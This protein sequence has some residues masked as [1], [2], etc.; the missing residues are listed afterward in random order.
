MGHA[1]KS[2]PRAFSTGLLVTAAIQSS[3]ATGLMIT[4]FA[5][6]GLIPLVPG[7][8]VMLGANIGTTL[9]VQVLSFNPTLLAPGFVLAGVWMFRHYAP[10]RAR[11]LGRAF[12]GLGLL[13][14]SLQGL[15]AIF[16][17]LKSAPELNNA[18]QTLSTLPAVALAASTLLTWASHSS[19]AVVVLIMSLAHHHLV[20]PELAYV[21]VLGANLGTAI[22]PVLEGGTR[23]NPASRRLP[24][25]NLG[26]RIVG[27]LSGMV[28][29]PW[30]GTVMSALG[31]DPARAIANFHVLFNLVIAACFLPILKPYA[32]MLQRV[33]P[34]VAGEDEL[35]R[36]QYLDKSAREVPV[37]ALT[38]AAR[39]SL[40]LTDMLGKSLS[41]T[42]QVL[43]QNRRQAIREAR[44][45]ND[46]IGQLNRFIMT[47]IAG[48][49]EEN[50]GQA[51]KEYMDSILDFSANISRAASFS[52]SS[53]LAHVNKLQKKRCSL[54]ASQE[55]QL[56]DALERL[57]QN[58]KRGAALLVS[59]DRSSARSL[60]TG[61]GYFRSLEA[62]AV[63]CHLKNLNNREASVA[64]AGALHLELLRDVICINDY[65]VHAAAYPVLARYG[66]L[67]PSRLRDV[68][69]E[70]AS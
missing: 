15:A 52:S 63:E 1:T 23:G 49:S 44:D 55:E 39:E 25:G 31:A 5:R 70:L 43:L 51:D 53:L 60:V 26:T 41:L 4:S 66:E 35:I 56:G 29:L 7:L 42:Q 48:Q 46:S 24:I 30:A 37:L 28:L 3:T 9:I 50:L 18:L 2:A 61:K 45:L 21:L 16:E 40:R 20:S 12:I 59:G 32:R 67:L 8:I 38:L 22:N 54:T 68:P 14:M 64:D 34:V 69:L 10:G 6:D 36:P 62:V 47:Y 13:L 57:K 58:L 27:C 19:V 33:L 65:I 17:P 11:D